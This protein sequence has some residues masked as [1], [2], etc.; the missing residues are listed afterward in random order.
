MRH[1]PETPAYCETHQSHAWCNHNGGRLGATGYERPRPPRIPRKT[2]TALRRWLLSDRPI[3]GS[4]RRRVLRHF[5]RIRTANG[6]GP[7]HRL[8]DGRVSVFDLL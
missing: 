2:K 7:F 1:V 3:R 5:Q 4:Q 6:L 8:P